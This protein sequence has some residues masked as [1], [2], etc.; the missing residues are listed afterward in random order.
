MRKLTIITICL[1]MFL[2]GSDYAFR[3]PTRT[4]IPV[5]TPA[6]AKATYVSYIGAIK[7]V[8]LGVK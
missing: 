1:C 8:D 3:Y 2:M 5:L 7:D 4:S 6:I